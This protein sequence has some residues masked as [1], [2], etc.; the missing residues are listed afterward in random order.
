MENLGLTNLA[1]KEG[2]F[3]FWGSV[4]CGF[5][6]HYINMLTYQAFGREEKLW[7]IKKV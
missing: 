6:S 4:K 2:K 7:K 1:F 5:S 3:G